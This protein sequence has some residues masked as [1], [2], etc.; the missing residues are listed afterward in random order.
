MPEGGYFPSGFLCISPII[1]FLLAKG[2]LLKF[3]L[4][5]FL[6][7]SAPS[8]ASV[9][10]HNDGHYIFRDSIGDYIELTIELVSEFEDRT[11]VKYPESDF[12]FIYLDV[13]GN[14]KID[15]KIDRYYS[16]G[17]DGNVC[18]GFL[19]GFNSVTPCGSLKSGARVSTYF[20]K[21]KIESRPHPIFK[22]LIPAD[23]FFSD[24]GFAYAVFYIHSKE[25][26]LTS[27][28]LNKG[29]RSFDNTIKIKK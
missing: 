12:S 6:S 14:G 20:S 2:G 21:S 11:A 27:Y 15:E 18:A 29:L 1:I 17:P 7:F 25:K 16:I 10:I 8:F 26:G 4:A 19:S 13:N 3:F 9:I 24:D 28:P 23:E 22:F 5:L